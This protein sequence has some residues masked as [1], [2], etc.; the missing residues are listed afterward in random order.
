DYGVVLSKDAEFYHHNPE[1]MISEYRA[2]GFVYDAEDVLANGIQQYYTYWQGIS[3]FITKKFYFEKVSYWIK[4]FF[5]VFCLI[6]ALI[7]FRLN[8]R[9]TKL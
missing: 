1:Q 4:W 7:L 2:A 6:L 5:P 8:K 3:H 9:K